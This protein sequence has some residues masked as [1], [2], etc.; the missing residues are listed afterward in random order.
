MAFLRTAV[1]SGVAIYLGLGAILYAT[2]RKFIYFPATDRPDPAAT[3]L[4]GI[5]TV[6]YRTA[7][8]LDLLGWLVAPA[9]PNG[10]TLVFFQGNAGHIGH[11]AGKI[12]PFL[13]A[14]YSVLLAGYRGYGGNPGRP[15][16]DGLYADGR[17]AIA[18]LQSRGVA[19]DQMILYGESLGSAVAVQMATEH[20]VRAL[21]LEAPFSSAVDV[22][23]RRFP[24]YP[25]GLLLRDRFDSA[26]RIGGIGTPLFLFH[27]ERDRVVSVDLGRR[28]FEAASE[29][30]R[31]LFP[32]DAGHNDLYDHGAVDAVLEFLGDLPA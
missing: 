17:A 11:R 10:R 12:V 24:I 13:D 9:R 16:E 4:S 26:A 1:V 23:R 6:D 31:A 7:D 25:T 19:P 14:G 3:S 15:T 27:G 28:L 2:Q 18:L 5:E 8:G 22:A 20:D 21:V 30:K 29:P 32:P